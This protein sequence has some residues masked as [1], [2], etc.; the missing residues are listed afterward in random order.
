MAPRTLV[1][2]VDAALDV[3]RRPGGT[4]NRPRQR[5]IDNGKP[6]ARRG[7]KAT[8]L[9]QV[10]GLPNRRWTVMVQISPR[11]RI[12]VRAVMNVGLM[13]AVLLAAAANYQG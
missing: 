8:G 10:A 9:T 6:V 11:V 7:R 1:P 13:V 5:S 4:R 3:V 2:S 12:A